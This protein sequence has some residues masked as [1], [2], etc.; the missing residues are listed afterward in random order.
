MD[1]TRLRELAREG[2]RAQILQLQTDLRAL[3]GEAR[4][5]AVAVRRRKRRPM[6]AAQRKALSEKMKALW[7]SKKR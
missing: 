2:L 7:A 3:E 1:Q 5:K 6:S 4:P